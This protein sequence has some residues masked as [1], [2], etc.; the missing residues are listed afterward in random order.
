MP[1]CIATSSINEKP[2]RSF[3]SGKLPRTISIGILWIFGMLCPFLVEAQCTLTPTATVKITESNN[4]ATQVIGGPVN[5]SSTG[6][7]LGGQYIGLRFASVAIPKSAT[8]IDARVQFTSAGTY[9]DNLAN[10]EIKG[11][12]VGNSGSFSSGSSTEISDRFSSAATNHT[13]YWGNGDGWTD[14]QA[15][16]SQRTTNLATIVQEIIDRPD[17]NPSNPITLLFNATGSGA[18]T[19][20]KSA[21]AFGN[22]GPQLVISYRVTTTIGVTATVSGCFNNTRAM[23]S[24]EVNWANAPAGD[25][26]IVELGGQRRA[27]FPGFNVVTFFDPPDRNGVNY[28][29]NVDLEFASPQIVTFEVPANGA[30]GTIN[31]YFKN[32]PGCSASTTFTA[33]TECPS[34]TC[35]SGVDL[36]GTAYNDF[37]ADGI[38]NA[39][40][41]AGVPGVTVTAVDCAGTSFTTVTNAYGQYKLNILAA[42]YPVRVEFGNLP[43]GYTAQGTPNGVDGRTTVQFVPAPDCTVDLGMLNP[44][45]YCQ[46][47]PKLFAPRYVNGNPLGGGTAGSSMS[48][49]AINDT[50]SSYYVFNSGNHASTANPTQLAT[51]AQVGALWGVAY[52]RQTKTIFTSA[53]LRRHAG[54]GPQGLGGIY[55]INTVT[56]A[57]TNFLNVTTSPLNIGLGAIGTNDMRGLP[58]NTTDPSR[59]A[60]IFPQVGKI[61]MGGLTISDDGNQ[62]YFVNLDDKKVYGLDITAYNA[63]GA[64]PATYTSFTIPNGCTTGSG[65]SRP[66]AIKYRRGKV[67]VGVV[68]DGSVTNNRSDLRAFVYALDPLA[69]SWTPTFNFPLTYPKGPGELFDDQTKGKNSVNWRT[70]TDSFEAITPDGK[71][72]TRSQPI[73]TGIEFDIDNSMILA[74]A[75]RTGLQGGSRNYGSIPGDTAKY[76]TISGGELLRVANRNGIYTLE[77]NGSVLGQK[78]AFPNNNQGPGLGEFYNDNANFESPYLGYGENALGG[79]ALRPGS[80][81]VVATTMSPLNMAAYTFK[82]VE[83]NS[84]NGFRRLSNK[85]GTIQSAYVIYRNPSPDYSQNTAGLG[86]VE[87]GCATASFIEIGNRVWTDTDRDGIQDPCESA[88]AGVNVTIYKAGT[89]IASTTTNAN[90]EYYFSSKSKLLI[91]SW[92]GTGADTTLLPATAYQVVFGSGGQFTGGALHISGKHYELTAA[93]STAP[94]ASTLNDSNAQLATVAGINAPTANVTTGAPGSVNHTLDAGFICT[95]T[96]VASVSVTPASCTG[97]GANVNG[98]IVLTGVQNGE[99]A[100]IY[101]SSPAPSYT[102]TG[103]QPVS[104]SAVSFTGLANPSNSVG[105]SYSIIIYN[106]PGC[107]TVVTATLPQNNCAG[108]TVSLT[109][110]AGQCS[111]ATNTFTTSVV[112][113]VASTVTGILTVADGPVSQTFATTA[114]T[115]T[116]YTAIFNGLP[117]NSTGR[118]ATATVP[119]CASASTTYSSPAS[120]S[121][122]VCSLTATANP[123]QCTLPANTFSNTVLIRVANSVAGTLTVTD[124]GQTRTFTTS[125]SPATYTATFTGFPSNGSLHNVVATLPGCATT[126]TTYT[127]PGSCTQPSGAQVVI[128]KVVDKSRVEIGGTITYTMSVSNTGTATASTIVVRDSLSTGLVYLGT[129]SLP[130]NTTFTPGSPISNWTIPS[131]SA[132]QSLSMTYQVRAD[133]SGVM[134]NVATIPGDTAVVCSSVPYVVC[135]GD[136]YIFEIVAAP[137]RSSYHWYKDGVEIQNNG[138][139][140]LYITAPGAYSLAVDIESGKCP[141]YSCCPFIVEE[142][143]LPS[144]QA[145]TVAAT[146]SGGASQNNGRIVLSNFQSTNTYQ[147]SLGPDFNPAASLS[148]PAQLIPA[149]GII[150]SNLAN[151]ATAQTYTIRVYNRGTCYTDVTVTLNPTACCN[152]SAVA[153][154]GQCSPATNTY[155]ATAVVTLTNSTTG[156]LTVTTGARSATFAVTTAGTNSYTATFANMTADGVSHPVVATL[157]GCSSATTAYT[158]PLSCSAAPVCSLTTTITS[159]TCSPA[160]NTYQTTVSVRILNS[161]G[162]VLT[163]TNG[164]QSQAIATTT[165]SD[166]TYPVVFSNLVSDGASHIVVTSLPGCSTAT[167]TY[168]APASCSVAPVCSLTATT[169]TGACVAATNTFSNTVVVNLTNLTAGVLTIVDGPNSATFATATASAG[170]YTA[171]F[172]GLVSNGSSHTVVAS[173]PGCSATSVM[174]TAPVSCSVAPA[175]S[176]TANVT[177]GACATATNTY[178]ATAVV[179]VANVTAGVLT[180]TNGSQSVTVATTSGNAT[181]NAIFND[182]ISDGASH[183]VVVSLPGCSTATTTYT[184]PASCSITPICSVTASAIAGQCDPA[185]STF[186]NT[187]VVTLNNPTAGILTVTDGPNSGTIATTATTTASY[188]LIFNG[189]T[190]DASSHT[191]VAT[192][193]G[194]STITTTYTAPASCSVAP[195]CSMT[196]TAIAGSCSPAT[197]TYSATAVVALTNPTAGVLTVTHG[198]LSLTFATTNVSSATFTAVFTNLISDGASHTVVASL[199]GC[200]GTTTTYTAPVSCS[201]APV[202][203]LT[204]ATFT[205]ACEVATNTFSNTVVVNLTNPTA[206]VLT[207]VDGPYSATVAT[208]A[209]G[210]ASYTAVFPGLI[211][212]GSSHTVIASLPGCSAITTTYTAPVSCSVAPVCSLTA[213]VTA[214][215]CATATNTYSATALVS[216]TNS[217]TGVLTVTNGTQSLTFATTAASSAT[218]A[219]V[220]NDLVSDAASH[221]VIASLPGCSTITTTYTA[222]A[223]CSVAPICSLTASAIAGQ[224]DPATSTFSS[225]VVVNLANVPAG[226]LTVTDGA[227]SLTFATSAASTASYTATF[228]GLTADAASHTVVASLPGCSTVTTTYTAPASCSVAPVCSLTTLVTVGN[229]TTATNTYSATALVQLVNPTA[230]VLT[231]TNGV[232]SQTF[233]TT[234]T[235]SATF[236]AVFTGLVSDGASHTVVATLPNCSTVLSTYSAPNACT[237]APA[238]SLTTTTLASQCDPVTNTFSNTVVIDLANVAAGVLTVTDGVE[239]LTFA[240]NAASVASYT[241]TF[242]GLPSDGT[243]RTV[244]TTVPGCS[245][246]TT[247]YTAP[248]SCS[249]APVCSLT[250]LVTV[251][252]CTTAT[253]TYS[254]TALVQLVN[255]TAGVLTVTNGVQSQTFVTTATSSATFA[256]VFTGL[257]SDGASHTVVAT[258]PNCST[259]LSTYLAPQACNVTSACSLTVTPLAGQCDPVTNTF[260]SS[261]IVNLTNVPTGV[262]TVTDGIESLTFATT[263]AGTASYT[264]TFNGLPSDGTIRTVVTTMP[265]CSTATT[266]YTAPVSCSVSAICSITASVVPGPCVGE[267][268]S[269]TVVVQMTNPPAGIL[270]VTDGQFHSSE[271]PLT[272]TTG[273]TSI[274]TVFSSL[275]ANG[276]THFVGVT[277]AGATRICS[278]QSVSYVAPSSC[279]PAIAVIATPGACDT[280]TNSYSITGTVSLTNASAGTINLY[281]DNVLSATLAVSTGATSVPYSITG[282]ASGTGGHTI[283]AE[284]GSVSSSTTF[285]APAA[286]SL[287]P[288]CSLTVTA[289]P[290]ICINEVY[291]STVVVQM[292]NPPAGILKINEGVLSFTTTVSEAT[293]TVSYSTVFSN[294]PANGVVH[295]VNAIIEGN[296]RTCSTQGMSYTAPSTCLQRI[297]IT[298]TPSACDT[299]TNSYSITGTVSLTNASAGTINLYIDTVKSATIAVGAGITSVPY[300]IT[301]LASGTGSHTIAAELGAITSSTIISAPQACS[302]SGSG[303]VTVGLSLS[304]PPECV[305][306]TNTYNTT[307]V[308]SFTNATNGLLTITDGT[309]TTTVN[310]TTG[311]TSVAYS[312]SGLTT[313][314][315]THTVVVT[316]QGQSISV[317]YEAPAA[318]PADPVC[319]LT[320]TATVGA[321]ATATNTHSVTALITLTNSTTG[322]LTV[323]NGTT[324]LT[325]ATTTASS[326]TFAAVFNNL[327]SDGLTH[328]IVATLPGCSSTTVGYNAPVSCSAVCSLS[329]TAAAVP[330]TCAGSTPQ[331]NGKIII[332]DFSAGDTYQYALGGTFGSGVLLSGP[333]QPIPAGGVIVSNLPNPA[334]SQAYT[335]RIYKAGMPG[336]FKD[337]RVLLLT[338]I[339]GCP[340]DACVPFV[341]QQTKRARRIGDPR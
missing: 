116:S 282:L 10:I 122:P 89:L 277:I 43:A 210:S 167:T 135:T 331:L 298:A 188:T 252:N 189:L 156:T 333:A 98:S 34:L 96:S 144:F 3:F 8:I 9:N 62:L 71:N 155:T 285:N 38:K 123:G 113:R 230:G 82:S 19:M 182:L 321:C 207:I 278:V 234:A 215:I 153:S 330:V 313:G 287:N 14:G 118:I 21:D 121:A 18:N 170:S 112:V 279:R 300:S 7:R 99:K 143:A 92:N 86:D 55:A 152:I 41:T 227:Q 280:P 206:G 295:A 220:F 108:C 147:Y 200:G 284:L 161:N 77:N 173:L 209:T 275:T 242:N 266:T 199:P 208:V 276:S 26:I 324:S 273:T 226:V 272:E 134:Y 181:Y 311:T 314:T 185:T 307:G 290:G 306:G 107:F 183:P 315:G 264:A 90:G 94:T 325:F 304:D 224:C 60:G 329:A 165:S 172:A 319:S 250:T 293:G 201:V 132:G 15:G 338:T 24:A 218:F 187:I 46:S 59:D 136:E 316:Y 334:A 247:T 160:T 151:P 281:I 61:G 256:A 126:T 117:A 20:A 54:L 327:P 337:V 91:G 168:T 267:V 23:V 22:A 326:A 195:V 42:N 83:V 166:A 222:P 193:P 317:T 63:G 25:S 236:A 149:G 229:C 339:C 259:V 150:V 137:G 274:T 289:T 93:G 270:R 154:A 2:I 171:V 129:T 239:S 88:L 1:T 78:G 214:G 176:L 302:G 74:F 104:A 341:I 29:T 248:A 27:V 340:A 308:V 103:G 332:S 39:G 186:S 245:T 235:S 105:Q 268:Y 301:G 133:S 180:I 211:S 87:I 47:N 146:C 64:A 97:T 238:C 128:D 179:Q 228:N 192:L 299:P 196:T 125:T 119:G 79:L 51:A 261:V 225:T 85:N 174:Y 291:S 32:N 68:C 260:S 253:N 246:A 202:C 197:N 35:T 124:G 130:A 17:W 271:F 49:L 310:V 223:S 212:N 57:V 95:I 102:A 232:Q 40:E 141:D 336:C 5:T 4:D 30:G 255:P 198:P 111:P 52:N 81:N 221:T 106:G 303:S 58:N 56:N 328:T 237:L 109:A 283:A 335:V 33:P 45:D 6:L 120:C 50:D 16:A 80:G 127:A 72:L 286:C 115:T 243:I 312:F 31:T 205:G 162:G 66:W 294:I 28:P 131:L 320:A 48:F 217:T 100:F 142:E 191:V 244:V 249:V 175:C 322:V 194:C 76:N 145:A 254:A 164:A 69:N 263:A 184:A 216:L 139:N 219:A 258:L 11:H 158:A 213:N 169:L 297:A 159:S 44:V 36:S 265:G 305:P 157:P 148:G 288:V 138:S 241:A 53:V 163:I 110:T 37:N 84:A 309:S 240:T 73:L 233:V 70:W 251:G 318:C 296:I 269:S 65:N 292:T 204:A 114:G 203:S 67:Y 257:V 177:A 13:E 178:S 262:L 101:T 190:A 12:N 231:V 140:V 75:D 323:I